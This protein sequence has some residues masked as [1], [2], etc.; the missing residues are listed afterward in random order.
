MQTGSR[1]LYTCEALVVLRFRHL[2]HHFL[3]PDHCT[4]ISIS[5]VQHYI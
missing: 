1:I 4:H 5:K 2:V 3:E